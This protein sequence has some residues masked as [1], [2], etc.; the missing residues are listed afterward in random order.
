MSARLTSLRPLS[1]F[2]PSLRNIKRG[3]VVG[4]S[5]ETFFSYC[6]K[7]SLGVLGLGAL[8]VLIEEHEIIL[9]AV[10]VLKQA[11]AKIKNKEEIP[12][13]FYERLLDIIANF[14]DKCHH[15]KEET[16]LF[17]LIE[18]KDADQA[19][20]ISVLL[21]E[22]QQGRRYIAGL[23]E[24]L[25]GNEMQGKIENAD[26]Y[27]R[28]LILHIQRESGLFPFW[29][30]MLSD[31][32]KEDLLEKFEEIEVRVIGAGKHQEYASAIEGLGSQI[33]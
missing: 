32:E 15:G 16:A 30:E 21:E 5:N 9:K 18:Q 27:A 23:R 1:F 8:E 29:M 2:L 20:S 7:N 11:T 3:C 25:S 17:P 13:G 12:G 19:K 10:E 33:R 28:L 4:F 14:A 26:G 24:A 31:G 6:W 22:H